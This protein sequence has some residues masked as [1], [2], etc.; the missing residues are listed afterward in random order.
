MALNEIKY[1]SSDILEFLFLLSKRAVRYLIIGGEAVIYYGHARLTGDI[2]LFYETNTGNAQN[3][4]L[5]LKD[6]W[7]GDIPEVESADELLNKGMVFQ[8]GVPPNRIDLIS[9]VEGVN[10]GEAWNRKTTQTLSYRRKQFN[11]NYIGLDDLISNKRA[12]G[13]PRDKEDLKFLK[14]L[15]KRE[16]KDQVRS[17]K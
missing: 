5:A 12:V 8:F 6:F 15:K 13:R 7:D 4:F 10:F 17:K 1:F 11:V 14:E 16:K 9:V 3:L 2:D